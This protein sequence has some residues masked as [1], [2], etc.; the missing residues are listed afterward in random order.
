MH[1]ASCKYDT[2]GNHG[3][4]HP[5]SP[6]LNPVLRPLAGSPQQLLYC[7]AVQLLDGCLYGCAWTA[8]LDCLLISSK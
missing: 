4:H 6:Y 8:G 5:A 7:A 3:H 1:A 2:M